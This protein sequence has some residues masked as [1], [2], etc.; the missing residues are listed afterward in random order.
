MI[1]TVIFSENNP[2]RLRILLQSIRKNYVSEFN[3][4]VLHRSFNSD[5][6]PLYEKLKTEFSDLNINCN[7]DFKLFLVS[8]VKYLCV[9]DSLLR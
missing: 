4:N 7:N 6:E 2:A 9:L 1:N 8:C 5:Y 3:F